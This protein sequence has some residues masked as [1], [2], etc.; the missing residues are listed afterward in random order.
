M[1]INENPIASIP[2]ALAMLA[3]HSGL[4]PTGFNYLSFVTN[5]PSNSSNIVSMVWPLRIMRL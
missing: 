5:P 4:A 3:G 2:K 1:A